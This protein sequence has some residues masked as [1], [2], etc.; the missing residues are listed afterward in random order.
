MDKV[1]EHTR[2]FSAAI[3]MDAGVVTLDN[4]EIKQLYFIEDIFSF[5]LVGKII[6]NDNRGIFE[7]GPLTGN[8][9]ITLVYGE[10]EENVRQ[11]KIYKINKIDQVDTNTESMEAIE[12]FFADNMFFIMNFL[13]FSRS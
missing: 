11:F 10:E 2:E 13:Q 4:A 1:Q 7:F 9:M 6:I 5:A 8:E 3:T 12:I